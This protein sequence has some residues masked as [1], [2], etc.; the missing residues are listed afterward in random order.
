MKP[1]IEEKF[2]ELQELLHDMD[3][4]VERFRS[5]PWLCR[6][7]AIRN[8]HHKNFQRAQEIVIE[9]LRMGVR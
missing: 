7:M 8:S 5:I 4:P 2:V 6:N 3:I 9:L 1:E